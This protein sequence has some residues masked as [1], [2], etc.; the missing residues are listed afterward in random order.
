M[1]I[2]P[3]GCEIDTRSR[4]DARLMPAQPRVESTDCLFIASRCQMLTS[5]ALGMDLQGSRVGR[6][7]PAPGPRAAR[8]HLFISV[9][10]IRVYI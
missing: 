4:Y 9:Q 10:C 8:G 7:W 5:M 1:E 3:A 6:S 2:Q